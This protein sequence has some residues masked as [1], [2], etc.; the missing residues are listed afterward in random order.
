MG[1]GLFV[2]YLFGVGRNLATVGIGGS[3]CD[4]MWIKDESVDIRT[5]SL[6]SANAMNKLIEGLDR[7]LPPARP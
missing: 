7:G 5:P 2:A 1:D 4:G 3:K 6:L